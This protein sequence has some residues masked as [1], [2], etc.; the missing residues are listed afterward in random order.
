MKKFNLNGNVTDGEKW[1]VSLENRGINYGDGIFET[2]R[3][4]HGRLNFWEDHYFRLMASMRIVRMEIPMQF[5]PEY[6]QQQIENTL[7][8]NNLLKETA[9][10]K[11]LVLRQPG[12]FYIPEQSNIDFVITVKQLPEAN[13]QLNEQGLIIDLFKDYYKPQGLLANL[14]TTSAQ[15]YTVAGVFCKEN[16]CDE[17]I[18]LNSHKEVVEAI[19]A[20]VFILTHENE[21][22]TP[23]LE[24][25]C[26]KGVMR[27][28]VIRL[29]GEMGYPVREKSFNPFALQ[30]AQEIFFTNAI[31][32]IQWVGRY[33]KK[34]FGNQ[35]SQKLVKRLRAEV[36]LPQE[37]KSN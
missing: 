26:L 7:E 37:I 5:S 34:E 11:I 3:Y 21:I 23:P 20:N 13:Y 8:A 16:Q 24:S 1:S 27:K 6:L 19:S 32:G 2:L 31:R 36:S 15:L 25:G 30:K 9:R 33:R 28:N 12:G 14:K 18:L 17:L 22:W 10:V 4:A 29:L 35:L